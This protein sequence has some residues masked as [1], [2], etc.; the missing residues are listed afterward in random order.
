MSKNRTSHSTGNY[1]DSKSKNNYSD[2]VQH[3]SGDKQ[4][5]TSQ[6]YKN[7]EDSFKD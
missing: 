2:S 6:S 3:E 4:T 7:S 1:S 5:K